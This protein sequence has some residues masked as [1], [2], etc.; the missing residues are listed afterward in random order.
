MLLD[1]F[2]QACGLQPGTDT[3]QYDQLWAKIL[4]I[5]TRF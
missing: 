4:L 5:A 3:K 2:C 1:H